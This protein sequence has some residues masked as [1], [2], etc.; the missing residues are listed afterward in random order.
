MLAMLVSLVGTSYV[1]WYIERYEKMAVY[2]FDSTYATPDASGEPRLHETWV[3]TTDGAR[4]LVWRADPAPGKPTILYLMGN[5]GGLRERSERFRRFLDRGFGIVAL[6]YR[7][8]SGSTGRPEE[9]VLVADALALAR[10]EAGPLVLYGESLG[11]AVAIRVAA[12]GVG[13]RLI[14]EAPFTSV[15]DLLHAQYPGEDLS[16]LVTQRWDSLATIEHVTLPLLVVHGD[17]DH[18]V[19]FEMGR[20]IHDRAGS[21]EKRFLKVTGAGHSGLWTVDTQLALFDFLSED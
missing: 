14:L 11:A 21:K 17:R 3:E 20:R 7:G 6:A 2:P 18:L 19:P 1:A 8:S 12:E 4:L 9:A 13:R 15:P 10:S 5:A 16:H